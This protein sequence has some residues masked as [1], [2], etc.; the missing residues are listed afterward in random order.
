MPFE[1]GI[2]WEPVS[3]H[4]PTIVYWEILEK[5][6]GNYCAPLGIMEKKVETTIIGYTLEP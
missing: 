6:N 2:G 1:N 5:T 3:P 4:L